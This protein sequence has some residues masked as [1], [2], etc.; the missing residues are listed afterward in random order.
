MSHY[1]N[2][3]LEVRNQDKCCWLQR[4]HNC[5]NTPSKVARLENGLYQ[6]KKKDPTG[7]YKVTYIYLLKLQYNHRL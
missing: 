4:P 2:I 7:A 3:S 6:Y 1:L 5:R